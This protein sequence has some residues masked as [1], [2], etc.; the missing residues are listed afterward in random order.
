MKN[1][2]YKLFIVVVLLIVFGAIMISSVSVYSSYKVTYEQYVSK[3]LIKT[4]Y[5]YFYLVR[6]IFHIV[7]SL[8][9]M[10]FVTKVNYSFFEKYAKYFLIASWVMLIYVL[11]VWAALKWAKWWISIPW[12]PFLI[13]PTEFLKV[14]LII[15]LAAA[16]KKYKTYFIYGSFMNLSNSYSL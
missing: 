16:F 10:W 12:I 1:I 3:W 7:V 15:F 11:I 13:Q 5:N 14:S 4:P 6:S 9:I 8:L 2:D